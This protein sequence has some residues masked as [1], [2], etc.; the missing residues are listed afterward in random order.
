MI[1]LGGVAH[2]D[3]SPLMTFLGGVAHFD[4]S[5]LM[6][7]LG[8]VAHFDWSPLMIFLGGEKAFGPS[9]GGRKMMLLRCSRVDG[10]ANNGQIEAQN[11]EN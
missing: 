9:F 1:F 4:W 3:W 11:V 7:F 8:G 6:I 2:F 5:P 10:R